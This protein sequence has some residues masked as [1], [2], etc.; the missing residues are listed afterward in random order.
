M[1]HPHLCGELLPFFPLVVEGDGKILNRQFHGAD[2]RDVIVKKNVV[3][4]RAVI[5]RESEAALRLG[6]VWA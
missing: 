2:R 4:V 5:G 1:C 3:A 6:D